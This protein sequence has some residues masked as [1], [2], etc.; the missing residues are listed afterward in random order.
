MEK[1]IIV[2]D[3]MV[4]KCTIEYDKTKDENKILTEKK[5]LAIKALAALQLVVIT[6]SNNNESKFDTIISIL[7][8]AISEIE[9]TQNTE[10]DSYEFFDNYYN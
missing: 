2:S 10:E 4:G 9:Q 8:S 3:K 5:E 1:K 7:Q 6:T